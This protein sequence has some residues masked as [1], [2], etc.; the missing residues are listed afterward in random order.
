MTLTPTIIAMFVISLLV[1]AVAFGLMSYTKG[2]TAMWPT[3][4]MFL[5]FD[6]GLA[7]MSRIVHTGA[8]VSTILPLMAAAIPLSTIL[9]GVFVLGESASPWKLALLVSACGLVL[10]A[11]YVR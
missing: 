7:L 10:V 9:Y 8:N 3:I 11:G 4:G 5:L 2:L 1:Q 6:V